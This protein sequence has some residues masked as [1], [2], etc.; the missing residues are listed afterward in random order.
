MFTTYILFSE[1]LNRHYIGHTSNIKNRL[2][3]HLKHKTKSTSNADDWIIVYTKDFESR[4][5]A[6]L[7]EKQIKS[8]CAA[9]F[10][11]RKKSD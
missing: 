10:L 11:S 6:Y 5:E 2:K 4:Q 7:H 8:I 9:R 3:E 1:A